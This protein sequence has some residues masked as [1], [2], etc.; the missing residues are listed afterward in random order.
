MPTL[1]HMTA[2][3]LLTV[4]DHL[5][6]ELRACQS[7]EAAAQR[8]V[9]AIRAAF[10]GEIALA[11]MFMTIPFAELPEDLRRSAWNVVEGQA[12]SAQVRPETPV[13]T[14]LGSHG[15]EPRWCDRKESHGHAAIPLC[16]L[17]FIDSIPMVARMLQ[18]MGVDLGLKLD[19]DRYVKNLLGVGWVGLFYVEDARTARDDHGRRVI[20]AADFV[21]THG[22]RTVFGLGKAY[23]NG[24]IAAFVAFTTKTLS[25]AVIE[26][27]V[28]TVN[29]FKA[30]TNDLVRARRYFA[31]DDASA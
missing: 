18:E 1:D 25:R 8:Y 28:P 2:H 22:I 12:L 10:G 30:S 29:L 20:P 4:Q 17:S 11:R 13:L 6:D 14:L 3:E 24:A 5:R 19:T 16:S 15:R 7:F 21:D 26:Q 9:T 23:G 27:L 31:P